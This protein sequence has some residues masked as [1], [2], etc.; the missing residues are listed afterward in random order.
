MQKCT[1]LREK[2]GC[3]GLIYVLINL[4]P[5]RRLLEEEEE[6]EEIDTELVTS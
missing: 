6:A 2:T 3:R 5:A 1:Y 4:E